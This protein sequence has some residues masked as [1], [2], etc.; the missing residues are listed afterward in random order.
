[1]NFEKYLKKRTS[2]FCDEVNTFLSILDKKDLMKSKKYIRKCSELFRGAHGIR[3]IDFIG[4][5][6]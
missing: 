1:M 3:H 4:Y 6:Y 5:K 2:I